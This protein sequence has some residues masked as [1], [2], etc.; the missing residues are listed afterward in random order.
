[1]VSSFKSDAL[2]IVGP[3]A[4]TFTG[5]AALS[6]AGPILDLLAV[7]LIEEAGITSLSYWASS[8]SVTNSEM[9]WICWTLV[10]QDAPLQ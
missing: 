3:T 7:E 5:Y 9:S 10:R 6:I 4:L 1:L 2:A 8:I